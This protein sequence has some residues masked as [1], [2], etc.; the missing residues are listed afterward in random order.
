[1]VSL[2]EEDYLRWALLMQIIL[3]TFP[4]QF[5]TSLSLVESDVFSIALCRFAFS[6]VV[7]KNIFLE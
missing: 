5:H 6:S 2:S 7:L 1:M 4:L 3:Y